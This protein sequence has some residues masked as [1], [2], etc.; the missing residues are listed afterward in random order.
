MPR[1]T[2]A[3]VI[4]ELMGQKTYPVLL[5]EIELK[6]EGEGTFAGGVVMT[7][8]S[9]DWIAS[10]WNVTSASLTDANGHAYEVLSN[11]ATTI[12]IVADGT[13]PTDGE[14]ILRRWFYL[15]DH[16]EELSSTGLPEPIEFGVDDLG[17][18]KVY[19][20]Y[21]IKLKMISDHEVGSFPQINIDLLNPGSELISDYYELARFDFYQHFER[22]SALRNNIVNVIIVFLDENGDLITDDSYAVKL[23]NQFIITQTAISRD[24]ITCT[25]DSLG[26]LARKKIPYKTFSKVTCEHVYK[27]RLCGHIQSTHLGSP[28]ATCNKRLRSHVFGKDDPVEVTYTGSGSWYSLP[29]TFQLTTADQRDAVIGSIVESAKASYLWYIS[30]CS[31]SGGFTR[32]ELSQYASGTPASGVFSLYPNYTDDNNCAMVN[33]L[34]KECCM[35]HN[36]TGRL[37]CYSYYYFNPNDTRTRGYCK[38]NDLIINGDFDSLNSGFGSLFGWESTGN[39]DLTDAIDGGVL[40]VN[41]S[42]LLSSFAM[43]QRCY[44]TAGDVDMEPANLLLGGAALNFIVRY[45]GTDAVISQNARLQYQIDV[46]GGIGTRYWNNTTRTWA[47]ASTWNSLDLRPYNERAFYKKDITKYIKMDEH[48]T[49]IPL[50]VGTTAINRITVRFRAGAFYSLGRSYIAIDYVALQQHNQHERFGG[51]PG[52]PTSKFWFV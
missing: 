10:E 1:T 14:Y 22:Y 30:D 51:F 38:P 8:T 36:N 21:P 50:T 48:V 15:S 43:E 49:Q 46:S 12:T 11:T 27:D 5:Y 2:S 29:D 4:A 20:P 31:Y 44:Y 7:D 18:A 47:V 37:Y 41:A 28:I 13:D 32:I 3:A 42:G 24:Q 40:Y 34:E 26:N 23:V 45:Y 33:I 39:I 16:V 9:K 17:R 25:V 35:G 52:I 6:D 19:L